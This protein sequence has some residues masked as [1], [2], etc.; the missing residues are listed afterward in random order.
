MCVVQYAT[1]EVHKK[2]VMRAEKPDRAFFSFLMSD[3]PTQLAG[4]HS[5]ERPQGQW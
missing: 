3:V 2:T 1:W 4:P 5:A